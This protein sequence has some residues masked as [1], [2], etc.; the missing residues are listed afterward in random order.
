[1]CP[2][3]N[4]LIDNIEELDAAFAVVTETW[5]ADG[6]TL[7][8]DKQDLLLGAGLSLLCK[9]RK[10]DHRG[11]AY[12]GVGLFFKED[13]CN[14]T[15]LNL[16]NPGNFEVLP[17]VGTISGLTR[18]VAVLACYIPPTYAVARAN[19]CLDYIE[20]LVIELKRRLKDPIIVV[21]GD[22]NQWPID[23]AL[24]EFRDIKER[25]AGPT[26]GTRTI[27]RTFTNLE[28][29]KE[30]GVLNPLQT[31]DDGH[32][33]QSDHRVFYLT[34]SIRRKER[35][36]WLSYSYRYNNED[37]SRKFGEWLA[38]KDWAELVQLPGS[39]AKAERYQE[40]LN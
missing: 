21:T 34:A 32:V 22:F 11:V 19:E 38:Q 29:V 10:P 37:S 7:E 4:S 27:D 8:E 13:L 12:G 16:D 15:Q 35:Y 20:E 31:D 28:T 36:R 33:R 40:E 39:D 18:K 9:N 30:A 2:K 3:I 26:R 5:L 24:E 23:A 6:K 25:A 14:F 1:M 17:T